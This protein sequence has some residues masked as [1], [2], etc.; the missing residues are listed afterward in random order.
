MSDGDSD[1]DGLGGLYFDVL[2]F[3]MD[4]SSDDSISDSDESDYDGGVQVMPW[5]DIA[6]DAAAA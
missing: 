3:A 2:D 1:E 4:A 5:G 6:L